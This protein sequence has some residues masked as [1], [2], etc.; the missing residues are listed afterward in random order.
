MFAGV[1]SSCSERFSVIV[2]PVGVGSY[3]GA[4]ESLTIP[5]RTGNTS[6]AVSRAPV[7]SVTVIVSLP[8][9]ARADH[10]GGAGCGTRA[11]AAANISLCSETGDAPPT[12]SAIDGFARAGT[13]MSRQ[14]RY[15][16]LAVMSP[17]GPASFG[18]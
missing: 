16:T 1:F 12:G 5:G 8:T 13:Q 10:A 14:I 6:N 9:R 15:R 4:T 2:A 18:T 7:V 3:T 11:R 17:P